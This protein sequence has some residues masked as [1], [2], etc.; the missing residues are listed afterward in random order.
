MEGRHDVQ[1]NEIHDDFTLHGTKLTNDIGNVLDHF[2]VV[3]EVLFFDLETLL[4][5]LYRK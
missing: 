1:Q 4:A 5:I 3:F 2:I